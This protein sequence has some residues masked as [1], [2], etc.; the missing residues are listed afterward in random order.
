MKKNSH[1]RQER[2]E[3]GA[4]AEGFSFFYSSIIPVKGTSESRLQAIH[5]PG[6]FSSGGGKFSKLSACLHVYERER[7]DDA[8]PAAVVTTIL[9]FRPLFTL[10]G[11]RYSDNAANVARDA[12]TTL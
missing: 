1:W 3:A 2:R 10:G 9:G 8:V 5:P 12:W 7:D 4:A 11:P 6:A